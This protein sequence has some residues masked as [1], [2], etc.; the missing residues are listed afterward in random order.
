MQV[1]AVNVKLY[2]L[3]S[4]AESV[5]SAVHFLSSSPGCSF[6]QKG[7][8]LRNQRAQ[9]KARGLNSKRKEQIVAKGV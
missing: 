1:C 2:W 5:K 8:L 4:S 3:K 7:A 9:D 6:V